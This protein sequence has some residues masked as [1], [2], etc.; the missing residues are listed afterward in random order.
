MSI[1][2]SIRWTE[3]DGVAVVEFDLIGEKV[4]KLSS[5]VMVRLDE[6]LAEIEK[7][8]CKAVV[9]LSGKPNIFIA[10]ADIDEI[11]NITK[12]E[13]FKI[14]IEKAHAIL[15]RL[16]DLPMPV[17]AAVHG[18][19]VG[20]GCE[21][22]MA[23]DYRLG[24]DDASTKIGLPEVQLGIIPG[25]GGC[26]RMPRII[27][28]PNAL[29]IILAGKTVPSLKAAKMGLIDE[30]VPTTLLEGRAM[31][32]AREAVAGQRGKRRKQFKPKTTMDKFLHSMVGRPVVFSQAQKTV[33]KQ[34]KV[35]TQP[36]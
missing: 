5:P 13:D 33:M 14:S 28:L 7:S 2:E 27:G 8:S 10:G 18:A 11:K 30:M 12:E 32:M 21:L 23:C 24:S 6:V 22:I 1:Q 15:N 19:C 34:S 3:K 16:E 29:D 31:E 35:F 17:I 25:F 20:G 36:R 4:N 9:L 26:V